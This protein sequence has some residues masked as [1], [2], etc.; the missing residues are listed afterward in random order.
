WGIEVYALATL[1]DLLG[2]LESD[3]R[4]STARYSAEVLATHRLAIADYRGRYGT[5]QFSVQKRQRS[6]RQRLRQD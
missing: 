5:F 1:D 3:A 6:I 4:P 2:Y